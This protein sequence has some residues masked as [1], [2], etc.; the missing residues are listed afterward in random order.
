MQSAG[1]FETLLTTDGTT[2]CR[3]QDDH[4]SLPS[5]DVSHQY[6]TKIAFIAVFISVNFDH[7]NS[8]NLAGRIKLLIP[9]NMKQFSVFL[10]PIAIQ[11]TILFVNTF[12]DYSEK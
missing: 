5:K 10:H 8:E 9:K 6:E 7:R 2:Q 11:T 4:N 3:N 1:Y 12:G